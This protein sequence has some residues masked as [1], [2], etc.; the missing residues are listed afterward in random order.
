[1]SAGAVASSQIGRVAAISAA[2]LAGSLVAGYSHPSFAEVF[3]NTD[4][5][6]RDFKH[7]DMTK[8]SWA[9]CKSACEAN[10]KCAAWTYVKP[11][12]QDAKPTPHCWLKS[13]VPRRVAN[14]CCV[15]GTAKGT[16]D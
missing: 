9:D 4:M 1:M 14:P 11:R 16:F 15:S 5:P 13:G 6:G 8:D 3:Q 7:F 10:G 12:D 2:L